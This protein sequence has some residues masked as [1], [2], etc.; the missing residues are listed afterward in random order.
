M[1]L[2]IFGRYYVSNIASIP[3]YLIGNDFNRWYI[4]LERRLL[5]LT[6]NLKNG[7]HGYP[8][9]K[10]LTFLLK[11]NGGNAKH[12]ARLLLCTF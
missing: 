12:I 6:V 7:T 11:L 10:W 9:T 8:M 5:W 3:D 4:C 1:A 2:A